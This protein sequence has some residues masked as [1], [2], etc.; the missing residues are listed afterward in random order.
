MGF[1]NAGIMLNIAAMFVGLLWLTFFTSMIPAPSKFLLRFVT[2]SGGVSLACAAISHVPPDRLPGVLIML[3]PTRVV[4]VDAMMFGA[5]ILGMAAAFRGRVWG[6]L[7]VIATI[8]GLLLNHRELLSPGS[9]QVTWLALEPRMLT[10]I[11]LLGCAG[12]LI[13]GAAFETWTRQRETRA[14]LW[15]RIVADLALVVIVAI[16]VIPGLLRVPP[17][18]GTA[19]FRD[20]TNDGLFATAARGH[21]MLLTGGD[22]H[23]AQ[24]RTRRPVLIDGGGL[25]GLPYAVAGAPET[26]K[27]LRDIYGIDF[28][29][30]PSEAHGTGMIPSSFNQTIWE[31]YSTGRWQEIRRAYNVT[32]V[33]TYNNWTLRLPIVAQNS[34]YLLYEIPE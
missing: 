13:A 25:D 18:T 1:D 2:V 32:Q 7:L 8:A 6:R 16:A 12:L 14:P 33:L 21:G 30:P 11:V 28:F 9:E 4:N 23:L 17:R 5:V 22:L 26:E 34:S 31:G 29:H 15:F 3:M 24:L 20:R 19:T 10:L 27:I